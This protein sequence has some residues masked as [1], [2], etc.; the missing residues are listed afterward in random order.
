MLVRNFKILPL[1]DSSHTDIAPL[2]INPGENMKMK[3]LI[4]ALENVVSVMLKL[5]RE[6]LYLASARILFDEL[7]KEFPQMGEHIGETRKLFIVP[8]LKTLMS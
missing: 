5:E 2:M 6:D 4:S 1:L 8:S 3:K 7:I